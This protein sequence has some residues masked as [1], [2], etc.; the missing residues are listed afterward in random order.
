MNKEISMSDILRIE[1][2]PEMI[3]IRCPDTGIPLWTVIRSAFL[4][5]IIG[6][7]LYG[8]SIVGAG[9]A[10]G[11]LP[12]GGR[13]KAVATMARAFAHNALRSGVPQ[14]AYPVIV[15]ASGARLMKHDG[16]YFNCL[17]DY[18]VAEA[19]GETLTIENTFNSVWPFPRRYPAVL[20]HTPLRV[21]GVVR[22]RLRA[23]TFMPL[24]AQL[25]ERVCARAQQLVGWDVG[26]ERRQWL[27]RYCANGAASLLPRYQKYISIF[28]QAEARLLI[29]EEAC[30]G[31][32]DNASAI[33]AARHS[34]MVTAEYQHGAVSAGHDAYNYAPAVIGDSA[35]CAI[36]PDYFLAFGKWWGEQI[37]A[38]VEVLAIG[39][40][41]RTHVL[42]QL[43]GS[44]PQRNDILVLGDG[45]DLPLYLD[46]CAQLAAALGSAAEVVFRPHPLER[47]RL[48]AY[49][50]ERV[51]PLVRVDACADIYHAFGA[52]AAVV[53]EV[54]TGLFEAIGLVPKVFIWDTPKARFSLSDAK[55]QR[56]ANVAELVS[57]LGQ[58]QAGLVSTQQADSVWTPNWQRN[59]K[60]FLQK[61]IGTM[62][63]KLPQSGAESA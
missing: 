38:P 43:P 60:E 39:N 35:Y 47:A 59:Y 2:D 23:R 9:G 5:L 56:F 49:P 42:A 25:I 14:Q 51:S 3:A 36:F 27:L 53:S 7:L 41:H 31:G 34:G 18:F 62:N 21:D 37:N 55:L 20:M 32:A 57:L 52:A 45:L 8:A 58:P 33:L 30:Y 4:R 28:K 46:L 22:G 24:S 11:A 50:P 1:D 26:A 6:D 16:R 40:P 12:S 17:S 54:S 19:P 63:S 29:K 15:M 10:Q 44:S 48:M 13:I 61:G